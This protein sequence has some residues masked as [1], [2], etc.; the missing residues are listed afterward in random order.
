M[1]SSLLKSAI[2]DA[3]AIRQ[4]ALENAKAALSEAFTPKLSSMLSK[5]IAEETEQ[6]I[7]NDTAYT[8]GTKRDNPSGANNRMGAP[9]VKE[10]Y[11][12]SKEDGNYSTSPNLSEEEGEE[13]DPNAVAPVAPEGEVEL[14]VDAPQGVPVDV[15]PQN[16]GDVHIDPSAAPQ[17]GAA[18]TAPGAV[19]T[20]G[21]ENMPPSEDSMELESIIKELEAEASAEGES[22]EEPSFGGDEADPNNVH[23]SVAQ[24][25]EDVGV[26]FDDSAVNG[27]TGEDAGAVDVNVQPGDV[28]GDEEVSL[29]AILRELE[30]EGM[31]E[32]TLD[33]TLTANQ[34]L[35]AH[36]EKPQTGNFGKD[37][38][39]MNSTPSK[40]GSEPAIEKAKPDTQYGTDG[41]GKAGDNLEDF[42]KSTPTVKEN[43]S[44]KKALAE[45]RQTVVFL[46][47]KINEVNLLNAKLLYTNKLF[48]NHALSNE[49][50]VKVVE[51]LDLTK[52]V[53]EVKLV[54]ATLAESFSFGVT[55]R[56]NSSLRTIT[57]GLASKP[58]AS[59]K[60]TA[61]VILTE[62]EVQ[63]AR[64]QKL[65]G[66]KPKAV[67]K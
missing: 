12:A 25:P 54:Y 3:K 64:F 26:D 29:E 1:S 55:K 18:P 48:R 22:A 19:P 8:D 28:A 36:T 20:A 65:A 52:N 13:V 14:D 40:G 49:Q 58:T 35:K 41:S 43:L 27:E 46:K 38:T 39:G 62:G 45:Y 47:G 59:T 11:A 5:K 4:T 61:K 16:G 6:A 63:A 53:R 37:K 66:I 23:V 9:V 10:T 44:L 31:D 30:E 50:K 60:P 15:V 21:A 33:E 42:G 24:A 57:E 32:D 34:P 2:A 56:V 67:L 51:S 7:D 17:A